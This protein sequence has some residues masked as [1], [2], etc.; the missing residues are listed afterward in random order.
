[1]DKSE[2][3]SGS[4]QPQVTVAKAAPFQLPLPP[5]GEQNRIVAKVDELMA[6][7]DALKARIT[8]VAVTQKHL[9]D[10]IMERAAA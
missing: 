10:A 4:A 9:A 5:I 8:D 6:I 2:M 1:M 3:I 7:C